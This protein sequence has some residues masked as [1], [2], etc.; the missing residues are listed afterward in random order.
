VAKSSTAPSPDWR[1][2]V[3]CTI[4]DK[5]GRTVREYPGSLCHFFPDGKVLSGDRP[6]LTMYR[7]DMSVIWK[8]N[9]D[10][11]HQFN[12][13]ADGKNILV[14]SS[15]IHLFKKRKTRFDR[16]LV[17][18]LGGKELKSYDLF[19]HLPEFEKL[20]PDIYGDK[21]WTVSVGA[22]GGSLPS[23]E[24]SHVNSF[25]EIPVNS[26]SKKLPPFKAAG[27]IVNSNALA[28]T[29]VLD[30]KLKNIL[31]SIAHTGAGKYVTI[32]HDVHVLENG[33][34]LFYENTWAGANGRASA[35]LEYD[36]IEKSTNI[37]YKGSPEHPFAS[38]VQGNVQ[39]FA[40]G[41]YLIS[42][43][44]NGPRGFEIN[45]SGKEILSI[46]S[47]NVDKEGKPS[48][49]QFFTRADLRSFLDSNKGL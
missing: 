7:A 3:G 34:L 20:R 49:L 29:F 16:L 39:K 44:T 23:F 11:H 30:D 4:V 12:F 24:Y 8:K 25:Y 21:V 2:I 15:S 40:D 17:L 42:E 14:Q 33:K 31:W 10:V 36:P 45:S 19:E 27:F 32:R 37:V 18:D 46:A 13:T 26:S 35:V 38:S 28:M 48:G 43:I 9:I 47:P 6:G 22:E 41:G 5:S 1:Y